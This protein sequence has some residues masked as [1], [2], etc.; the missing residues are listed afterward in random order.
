[1]LRQCLLVHISYDGFCPEEI[2]AS[3]LLSAAQCPS[4]SQ[5]CGWNTASH[6]QGTSGET[7]TSGVDTGAVIPFPKS[8][9]LPKGCQKEQNSSHACLQLCASGQGLGKVS[10]LI[11]NT[12]YYA[13]SASFLLA[14]STP[15]LWNQRCCVALCTVANCAQRFCLLAI[16]L[17]G[18]QRN[19]GKEWCPTRSVLSP[20][21]SLC[22]LCYPNQFISVGN[23]FY[24]SHL[25]DNSWV[26]VQCETAV[27]ASF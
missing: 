16:P 11:N 15:T 1:M 13:L 18:S 23:S 10:L 25:W 12:V 7:C 5:D 27:P 24:L 9:A 17:A 26:V 21:L 3:R 20:I 6:F 14:F 4:V 19:R 2:T 22:N 8:L